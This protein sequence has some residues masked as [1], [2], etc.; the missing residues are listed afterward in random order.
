MSFA[1]LSAVAPTP[2]PQILIF[3]EKL[4]TWDSSLSYTHLLSFSITQGHNQKARLVIVQTLPW[5]C[6]S[7]MGWGAE[8]ANS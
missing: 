4:T 1:L 5:L 6:N 3:Q 2:N 7:Y 8:N